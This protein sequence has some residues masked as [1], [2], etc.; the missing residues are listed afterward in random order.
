MKQPGRPRR[1]RAAVAAAAVV[2]GALAAGATGPAA[3]RPAAAD[4]TGAQAAG[5]GLVTLITGD[6][7]AVDDA[8]EVTGVIRAPGRESIPLRIFESGPGTHVVPAD[9]LPL[10]AGGTLDRRL[11]DVTELSREQYRARG[12]LPLIVTY[13]N[14]R[15]RALQDTGGTR[16]DAINGE[17]FT[18]PEG[19][20]ASL[21]DTLTEPAGDPRTL[22]AA[23]GIESIGLDGIV[24]KSLA[25]S[26]PQI[27][28]PEAWE[29]GHDGTGTTIAVLDTG[30]DEQHPD[31][32]GQVVAE[33][34]F[35]DAP[36]AEDRDGHGTHVASTAA[37]TGAHSDG[38][39]RGVAPGAR[40][41]NGK[42]LDDFG[43][44]S[45]SG[46]IAGMEWAVEQGADVVNMSLGGPAGST[47]DPMEEAVNTLSAT[48]DTL[49]VVAAGNSGPAPGT[50]DSP[51]A[52]DAALTLGAVDKS[53]AL[54]DFS[55]V[56]PRTRDGAVKPDITAP[57][58]DI[59]A[60][61]AENAAIWDYGDPVA[62]GYVAISGTSMATPHAAGAAALLAQANPDWTGEQI[63]AA[64]TSSARPAEG[65]SAFQQ[66]AGRVDVPAALAQTVTADPVSL[67]FGAVP[68]PHDEAEPV[69]K[70]LT[71]SNHGDTDVTL[72]L[73]VT[74]TGPEGAP[75]PEGMFTLDAAE[76][77][78]PAHGTATVR[79]TA[80]T[81][82][83]GDL[84]G[85]YGTHVTATG[86]NG[87]RVVTAG[88]VLREEQMFEVTIEATD[89]DGTPADA[90]WATLIDSETGSF[91]DVPAEAGSGTVRVPGGQYQ[92][93]ATVFQRDEEGADT[94]VDWLVQPT[95]S[96]T[97]DTAV[98]ADATAA[99]EISMTLAEE[100]SP[101]SLVAGYRLDHHGATVYESAWSA[102]GLPEG[103]R[104]AQIAEP[105]EGWGISGFAAATWERGEVVYHGVHTQEGSFYT[106]LTD[107]TE[108][109]DL[110]SVTTHVGASLPGTTGVLFTVSSLVPWV[111]AYEYPLPRSEQVFVD[112][113]DGGWAHDL[114]QFNANGTYVWG[115][116]S[117]YV[118]YE[119]GS[120]H[121]KTLGVG[122]FGPALGEDDGLVRLGDTLSGRINPFTDGQG[123][124]GDS[125]YDEASTTL[126]RDGEEF[127]TAADP[128]DFVAFELPPEEADYELVTTVG[129][130]PDGP[131]PIAS[132]STRVTWSAAF[133]SA[134]GPEDGP[135]RVPA[136]VVRFT[137][138]LA[139]D[140]TSPAGETVV[141]PVTVQ[142]ADGAPLTVSV[143][144]DGGGTWTEAP[145][146]D[147][148]VRVANPE[149]GGSVSFR[150]ELGGAAGTV[151]T[152]EIIDAY[153]TA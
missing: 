153:R 81:T 120:S 93:D 52:A 23:P 64:L 21:W 96:V 16:L 91:H 118:A 10:L 17:A 90:W 25:E 28:A 76:V 71:Y 6:R 61:G 110:A 98:R 122:V 150:A 72:D 34:N 119:A 67:T 58:A 105:G 40:L 106:G 107:R 138:E 92:V 54:A 95:L 80:D 44:G 115:S 51:G 79:A 46:I 38:A 148:A 86:E 12:G 97:E 75:A 57:G 141:V 69:T 147:G 18:V 39:Y 133:T 144:T 8:G 131:E 114:I 42:V 77:T 132:V 50:I 62:D 60:A 101:L 31:L 59:G 102:G 65:Y 143:S 121:E 20:Q 113:R 146:E 11:F 125:L 129:R 94:G 9:A 35:S 41:L 134:A 63:K 73:A 3:A 1:S 47:I 7:V 74:G 5:A 32:V 103:F 13:E 4:A 19:E 14:D 117:D 49:F 116:V 149:A 22:T 26:V 84:Y 70:E 45:E 136:G 109:E 55:S 137:P 89:R 24:T 127:A 140:S 48:S 142:G 36:D 151:V 27:G 53:D 33:E 128:L 2:A 145:V 108:T 43:F 56:G 37:G 100:A 111:G 139:L 83:G 15:P 130:S 30:I 104:T 29:A 82:H 68:W 123:N 85:T 135:V 112:T 88:A 126:Y 99:G 124:V 78:V 66:G 87:E 152:Q